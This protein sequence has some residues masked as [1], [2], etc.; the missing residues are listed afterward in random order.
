M[1][2]AAEG[3]AGR[4]PAVRTIE[5]AGI[6]AGSR[7]DRWFKRRYPHLGHGRIEKLLRTGQIR[8]DGKRVKAGL[9]L[10]KGMR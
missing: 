9:R 1:T 4:E 5:V 8:V 10:A 7:L 2:G 6:E 3:G